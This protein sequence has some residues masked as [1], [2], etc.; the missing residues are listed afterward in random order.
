MR[1]L[2][3]PEYI[4]GAVERGFAEKRQRRLWRVDSVRGNTY[5][6]VLS[7]DVPDYAQLAA[8]YGFPDSGSAC[9]TKPYAPLLDRL[10]AGQLWQFRLKAN[11][12]R[13]VKEGDG[14]GKV[15]A[16]VTPQQ[17]KDW[18]AQRAEKYGFSLDVQGFDVVHTQWLRFEKQ[19][20]RQVS[21]RTATFEGV[22]KVL[23]PEALRGALREGI[24]RAK[25]Y[26]CGLMTLAKAKEYG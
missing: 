6:L 23:D 14:R 25:A 5:L 9:E 21:L 17:Q 16:H 3:S 8:Q 20:G 19:G 2:S 10:A 11:P 18:L 24:G 7:P 26:G 22:L 15:L 4:H 12:V 1:L 13:S